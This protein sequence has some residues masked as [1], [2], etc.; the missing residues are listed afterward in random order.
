MCVLSGKMSSKLSEDVVRGEGDELAQAPV[1]AAEEAIG[2]KGVGE[3]IYEPDHHAATAT[4]LLEMKH[5]GS[6]WREMVVA[7]AEEELGHLPP[8]PPP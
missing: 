5:D 4:N 1:D 3:A 8:T 6:T 7:S 2:I